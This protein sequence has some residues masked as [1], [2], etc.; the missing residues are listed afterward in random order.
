[1]KFICSAD[2]LGYLFAKNLAKTHFLLLC[3]KFH[4]FPKQFCLRGADKD[5]NQRMKF[6]QLEA[7]SSPGNEVE[8]TS[9]S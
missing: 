7:S 9:V 4:V 8:L 2:Q 6:T 5:I 3:D 1:V